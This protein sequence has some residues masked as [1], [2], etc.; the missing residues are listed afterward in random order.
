M[1]EYN[2][3]FICHRRC[4]VSGTTAQIWPEP[5]LQQCKAMTDKKSNNPKCKECPGKC[6]WE[7]HLH[8]WFESKVVEDVEHNEEMIKAKFKT[9]C[10]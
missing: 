1:D 6:S 9:L 2:N 8:I 7:H 3:R 4:G 5:K 10:R